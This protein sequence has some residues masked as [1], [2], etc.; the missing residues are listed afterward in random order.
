[1]NEVAGEEMANDPHCQGGG[2]ANRFW[3]GPGC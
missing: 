3:P 1:M 2:V